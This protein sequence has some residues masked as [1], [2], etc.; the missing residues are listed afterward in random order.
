[1]DA[2]VTAAIVTSAAAL[3]GVLIGALTQHHLAKSEQHRKHQRTVMALAFAISDFRRIFKALTSTR[4]VQ[5]SWDSGTSM[6]KSATSQFPALITLALEN[7][8]SLAMSLIWMQESMRN[9][10]DFYKHAWSRYD[11][12]KDRTDDR[13]LNNIEGM[14]NEMKHA[15]RFADDFLIRATAAL[16]WRNRLS[17]RRHPDYKS[18]WHQMTS[19]LSPFKRTKATLFLRLPEK[20]A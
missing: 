2:Q 13:L 19:T 4:V 15:C 5:C 6:P 7:E 8:P 12:C 10:D 1:M 20:S 16:S 18:F 14:A 17:M 3:A 9:F 11:E